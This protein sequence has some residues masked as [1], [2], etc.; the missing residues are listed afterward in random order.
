MTERTYTFR[1][2]ECGHE[3]IYDEPAEPMC[4]GPG[5]TDDHPPEVMRRTRV[6]SKGR[7][8]FVS[9]EEAEKLVAGPLL[10]PWHLITTGAQVDGKPYEPKEDSLTKEEKEFLEVL[11]EDG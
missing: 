3:Y 2:L 5:E 10:T 9:P 7:D 11:K 8:K 6:Q 4:T 1:C